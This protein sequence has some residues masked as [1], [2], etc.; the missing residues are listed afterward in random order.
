M[1][2]PRVG[3]PGIPSPSQPLTAPPAPLAE[4]A[5]ICA[6][7]MLGTRIE[8]LAA[9]VGHTTRLVAD[10][11]STPEAAE[12]LVADLDV[13]DPA[14]LAATG[15]PVVAFYQHT[16]ADTRRAAEAA[17]L[18]VIAPRSK[19]FREFGELLERAIQG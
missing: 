3:A 16:D 18:T 12:A 17:G 9:P 19:L 11:A 6:D 13:C 14:E 1:G 5:V 4:I 10:L 2:P 15:K 7:L 8:G